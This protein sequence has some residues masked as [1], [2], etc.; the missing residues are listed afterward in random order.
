MGIVVSK[1][2]DFLESVI[3]TPFSI[4]FPGGIDKYSFIVSK[5]IIITKEENQDLNQKA[6]DLDYNSVKGIRSEFSG[7]YTVHE[8][9]T[10]DSVVERRIVSLFNNINPDEDV[11]SLR[12]RE[13]R[14]GV[15]NEIGDLQVIGES[16]DLSSIDKYLDKFWMLYQEEGNRR[17]FVFNVKMRDGYLQPGG[18]VWKV[19]NNYFFDDKRKVR[20]SMAIQTII[21]NHLIYCHL[22]KTQNAYMKIVRN[23]K[24][25]SL[26][27]KDILKIFLNH[28]FYGVNEINENVRILAGKKGSLIQILTGIRGSSFEAFLK[29]EILEVKDKDGDDFIEENIKTKNKN[30]NE[31]VDKVWKATSILVDKILSKSFF[32]EE[33]HPGIRDDLEICHFLA[34]FYHEI[35]GDKQLHCTYNGI[36]PL[37]L[38]IGEENEFTRSYLYPISAVVVGVS[39]RAIKIKDL[40]TGDRKSVV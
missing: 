30:W 21:I 5:A 23:R 4:F 19:G 37:R 33:D 8:Y 1:S 31:N 24:I 15:E 35:V 34:T 26:P 18:S 25:G 22:A 7:A 9:N 12:K 28:L 11:Y 14:E 3:A 20:I 32:K 6:G 13:F 27:K 36:L 29:E 10:F 16:K 17:T 40:K 39:K 2:I 38:R